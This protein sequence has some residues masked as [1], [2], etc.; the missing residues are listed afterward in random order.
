MESRWLEAFVVVAEEMHFGRA[1]ERLHMSQS[2]LSQMIR[3][4]EASL[5][6]ELFERSTRYV[7]LAPAGF[8]MLPHAR[9][10]LAEMRAAADSARGARGEVHGR[11]RVGFSGAHNH[12][13]LPKLARLVRERYPNVD[14]EFIADVRT[15]DGNRRLRSG[16]LDLAFVGVFGKPRAPLDVR[17]IG[18]RRFGA[19]V[20]SDHPLAGAGAIEVARLR[21]EP[22]VMPP[23]DGS[24]SLVDAVHAICR[25]A[26]FVPEVKQTISDPFIALTL[27]AAGVGVSLHS[28]EMKPILPEHC[29]WVELKGTSALF[30]HG[31]AWNS[32]AMSPALS[33]VVRLIDEEMTDRDEHSASDFVTTL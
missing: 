21:D 11:L 25:S 6:V 30:R 4:L 16:D 14:L 10:A 13:S 1:A 8:A 24:S 33:A 20:P 19:V 18:V 27:V 22:F 9:A 26:G 2:P 28:A 15:T 5:G 29:A 17:V 32:E 12:W 3:R 7:S 23:N 31:L